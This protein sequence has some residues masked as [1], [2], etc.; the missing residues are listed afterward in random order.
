MRTV[1]ILA[2]TLFAISGC[3]TQPP[4]VKYVPVP[5]GYLEPCALPPVPETNAE[6]SDAF[7]VAWLCAEQGNTDKER[8]RALP[9]D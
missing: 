5:A 9:R 3:A 2:S 4:V 1:L 6:L 7:V 8:I